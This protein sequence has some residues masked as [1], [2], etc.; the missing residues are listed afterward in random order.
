MYRGVNLFEV[1]KRDGRARIG[2]LK[3]PHGILNTPALL[4]VVN[5][6][7]LTIT[8][9]EMEE[10]YGIEALITNSYVIWK[11]D[12]LKKKAET[13]GVHELLEYNG[14]VMTDSGTFQQYV[15]G[16]IDVTPEEI[17]H[18]QK[19]IGVDIAT[20]MDIFG[21]PDMDRKELEYAV[22]ETNSRGIVALE[23]SNGTMLNG[24]IQGGLK[25]DLRK[26]SAQLMGNGDFAIHA[27]GGVVPLMEQQRYLELSKV[28]LSSKPY[29]PP[30]RP[31]HLF[32]CGHPMLF[33]LA[34][35]LGIDMF[36]SAA[37]ALFAKDGR[38]MTP[39]ST[40]HL[41]DTEEWPIITP[42]LSKVSPDELRKMESKK[43]V[44]ILASHNLEICLAELAR[45]REAIRTK[46]IWELVQ[47]R[48]NENPYLAE[49]FEWI[50]SKQDEWETESEWLSTSFNPIRTGGVSWANDTVKK[51]P[52]VELTKNIVQN[53]W[54][55]L[56]ESWTDNTNKKGSGLA[57]ILYGKQGPW[58]DKSS[59]LVEELISVMPSVE[60]FVHTPLGLIPW[61]LEDVNPYAHCVAS[62][63]KWRMKPDKKRCYKELEL[64]N[65]G[66]RELVFVDTK[67]SR[68]KIL[69]MLGKQIGDVG[70]IKE[71]LLISEEL[72]FKQVLDKFAVFTNMP[73]NVLADELDGATYAMS[74]TG[75]IKNIFTSNNSHVAS[76]RLRDGGLS[77]TNNGARLCHKTRQVPMPKELPNTYFKDSP[78]SGPPWV[79]VNADAV[80]F[81][82]MGRNVFHQFVIASD[83]WIVPGLPCLIVDE[84]GELVAHG[85]PQSPSDEIG[86][87]KKGIAIKVK[88][89]IE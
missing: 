8:P 35:A 51:R 65:C 5:P 57:I 82:K 54:S 83:S 33:P 28:I 53:R 42:S 44:K 58:R 6:N 64:L 66:K 62:R 13:E 24:P 14:C 47:N 20:M 23:L 46:R 59:K 11:T 45:C 17:I 10:K 71:K 70:I 41:E 77:L 60:I 36:D 22:D 85:I 37:Y 55:P 4:P 9:K 67:N 89:G 79:V 18:F 87:M 7:V 34:V 32:G 61:G 73:Y 21:R 29:L 30:N 49:A 43:R 26:R 12:K 40:I 88:G 63:S 86:K 2:Q 72:H 1:I 74:S 38:I 50:I 19:K 81:A 27:I 78:H 84:S 39:W 25:W 52:W 15:Y 75:R 69:E 68:A 80:P 16:D 76:P 3:T 56:H 48:C 31:V